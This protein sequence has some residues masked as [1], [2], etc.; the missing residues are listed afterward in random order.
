MRISEQAKGL[1]EIAA[2]FNLDDKEELAAMLDEAA[3][4]IESL[5]VKLAAADME[6]VD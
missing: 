1:G 5:T 3:N 4:T 6:E 2:E